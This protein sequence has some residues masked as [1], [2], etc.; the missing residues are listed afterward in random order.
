MYIC[1]FYEHLKQMADEKN[2]PIEESLKTAKAMGIEAVDVNDDEMKGNA[3]DFRNF[4]E[5]CGLRVA[6]VYSFT[7]VLDDES[8]KKAKKFVLAASEAGAKNA[9]ILPEDAPSVDKRLNYLYDETPKLEK[10][11]KFARDLGLT[12]SLENF[13]KL[14][15]P[16]TLISDFEYLFAHTENVYFTLDTGN[17]Y[18]NGENA[19]DAFDRFKNRISHVH[20]KTWDKPSRKNGVKPDMKTADGYPIYVYPILG[21][22]IVNLDYI[23]SSLKKMNYEGALSIEIYGVSPMEEGLKKSIEYIDEFL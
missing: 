10:L 21:C 8:F 22:G 1:V 17:F 12:L 3:A 5:S 15:R 13:S 18:F 2:I 9:M 23:L 11:G 20:L 16:Y 4:V 6:S 19:S 14:D 7:G